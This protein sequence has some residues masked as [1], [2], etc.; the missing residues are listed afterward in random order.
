MKKTIL[1][2][3]LA[4]TL[5]ISTVALAGGTGEILTAQKGN[6]KEV[7]NVDVQSEIKSDY[8]NFNGKIKEV[9]KEDVEDLPV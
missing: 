4:S 9:I 7:I 8:I 1:S 3:S 5:L 6:D 2:L